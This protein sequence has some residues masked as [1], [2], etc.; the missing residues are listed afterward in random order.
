MKLT[1]K[2]VLAAAGAKV[3]L[4]AAMAFMGFGS[5]SAQ[6]QQKFGYINIQE[7]ITSMPEN[8]EAETVMQNLGTS[9]NSQYETMRNEYFTKT[10]EYGQSNSTLLETVRKQKE[11][12]LLDLQQRLQDFQQSAQE[13]MSA[14]EQELMTP[15][16]QK[17]QDAI[18]KVSA[19]QGLVMTIS[20]TT[21][22]LVYHDPAQMTDILPLV[23]K[24][25]G[26]VTE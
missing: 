14:K 25:L 26:I 24:E 23:R 11:A 9:L 19:A 1:W 3:A 15:I 10:Q 8:K 4:V 2:T 17:A 13:E 6:A 12:E 16:M 18:N 20:L 7:L 5:I 22:A 21:G